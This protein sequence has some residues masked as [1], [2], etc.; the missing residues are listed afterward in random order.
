MKEE[1]VAF[2]THGLEDIAQEELIDQGAF[3]VTTEKKRI[4][5]SFS[6]DRLSELSNL[7]TIDD[8]ALVIDQ[9]VLAED[10]DISLDLIFKKLDGIDFDELIKRLESVREIR[11]NVSVTVSLHKTELNRDEVVKAVGER[12]EQ[13]TDLKFTP[14]Q[15]DNIDVR[16]TI[17]SKNIIISV[18]LFE[19]PLH[20]RSYIK[21]N[22]M[23]SLKA[24]IAAG[25]VKMSVNDNTRKIVDLFCGS[26][27]I[28][29]EASL[30]GDFEIGGSD[31][32][33]NALEITEAR[34]KR[35]GHQNFKIQQ[36]DAKLTKWPSNYFDLGISNMPWNEKVS[37]ENFIRM[38]DEA[39][40]E[41][42]RIITL[43]GTL[44][45]L[46]KK[47]EILKDKL[48]QYFPSSEVTSRKISFNGQ[49][50]W[51]FVVKV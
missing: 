29:T 9:S 27:T 22:Y 10:E 15:R 5:F 16:I 26:G 11:N 25:L 1:L 4:Q 24:T 34:L 46:G 48:D 3:N 31:V 28:L 41:Y 18:R 6:S 19:L 45:I 23:G 8:V 33:E 12:I 36:S 7:R 35:I 20:R 47:P 50:P 49:E 17:D 51:A 39:C 38:Y 14:R 40:R 21:E 44:C 37:V 13:S 42:K 30:L 2:A 43:D 32:N